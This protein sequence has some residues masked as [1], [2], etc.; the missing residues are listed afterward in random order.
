[1]SG[2]PNEQTRLDVDALVV[3]YANDG[4]MVIAYSRITLVVLLL[5]RYPLGFGP[6]ERFFNESPSQI[7]RRMVGMLI[8]VALSVWV[9]KLARARKCNLGIHLFFSTFDVFFCFLALRSNVLWG[10]SHAHYAGLLRMPDVAFLS[11]LLPGAAL[12]LYWSAMATTFTLSAL[13]LAYLVHL[14]TRV[15]GVVARTSDVEIIAFQLAAIGAAAF[16]SA[17][18]IRRMIRRLAR[19]A[20]HVSRGR[21]HLHDVL[22]EHH[23]VR[24][25]LSTAQLQIGFLRRGS[26]GADPAARLA[27][28]ERAVEGV[29][30]ILDGIKTR[31]FGELTLTDDLTSVDALPIIRAAVAIV[32]SRF[33]NVDVAVTAASERA[34][35]L[36]FGGERAFAHVAINLLVNACEGDGIRRAQRVEVR[37]HPSQRRRD[38]MI[39]EF[40]DDGPGFRA[41]LLRAPLK[42]GLTTKGDGSGLGLSLIASIVE[43]SG[44]TIQIRNLPATGACVTLDLGVSA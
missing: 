32:R 21:R 33:P 35:T 3:A 40:L 41:E 8:C 34:S 18:A 27:A 14:D 13:S 9:V 22:R 15:N 28:V 5:V 44:G 42:G 17:W 4:E 23:D 20:E 6:H 37:V 7:L 38:R 10:P 31:T 43:A 1:M 24:T 11:M 29:G 16:V 12:R 30:T 2:A 26:D 19:E 36:L 25:L 39:F